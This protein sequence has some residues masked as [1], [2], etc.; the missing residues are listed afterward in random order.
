[1][2]SCARCNARNALPVE[3]YRPVLADALRA[4]GFSDTDALCER[5]MK[6]ALHEHHENR[7]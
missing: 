7:R 6:K 2:G 1:M 4:K 5:C 3:L